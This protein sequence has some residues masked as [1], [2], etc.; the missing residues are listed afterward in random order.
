MSNYALKM[1][2]PLVRK[3]LAAAEEHGCP[4]IMRVHGFTLLMRLSKA[5]CAQWISFWLTEFKR[6]IG[7]FEFYM[8]SENPV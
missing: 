4:M 1:R 2:E 7:V 3:R 6:F 5:G 8:H